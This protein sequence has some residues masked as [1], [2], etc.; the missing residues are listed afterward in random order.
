MM[1][2]MNGLSILAISAAALAMAHAAQAAEAAPAAPPVD[3]CIVEAARAF[4]IDALPLRVLHRTEAGRVG[5][6]QP[7][8]DGSVDLGPMQ[9][10]S[11]HLAEFARFGIGYEDLRD[12]R[13]CANVLAAAYL[14]KRHLVAERGD[15]AMAIADYH[16]RNPSHALR[17]LERVQQ[18]IAAE[19]RD[20]ARRA[21]GSPVSATALP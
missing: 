5:L 8:D 10:N 2:V 21:G 19:R 13:G 6:A 9:V 12:N 3:A 17:Y 11:V 16:S 18:A 20:L 1:S 14:F 4:A 7:N 15:V